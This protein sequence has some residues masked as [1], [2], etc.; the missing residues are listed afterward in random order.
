MRLGVVA[1]SL[2][3]LTVM[4]PFLGHS[5]STSEGSDLSG[6]SPS[7]NRAGESSSEDETICVLDQPCPSGEEQ[8]HERQASVS[9]RASFSSQRE[10]D[11]S[12]TPTVCLHFWYAPGCSHCA[13]VKEHLRGLRLAKYPYLE[14]RGHNARQE[15]DL[16]TGLLSDYGVAESK[17]GKVPVVYV[18]DDYCVGDAEC[19]E[20]VGA[21]IDSC[22]PGG[23]ACRVPTRRS[24]L[25][26]GLVGVASLAAVDAVNVCAL[27]VLIILITSV[28]T[29]FPEDRRRMLMIAFAFMGGI[30]AAYF[31]VGMLIV[32]GFKS[33][34]GIGSLSTSWIYRAVGVIAIALGIFNLKDFAWYG[35][36]G[37]KLEVPESWRPRMKKIIGSVVSPQGAL[38]VGLVVSVFLLP[39][40]LGPYF[41]AS[42]LL[43]GIPLGYALGWLLV[44]N[45]VFILPMLTITFVVYGGFGAI[46]NIEEWRQN[47]LRTLHLVAGVILCG[48]GAAIVAGWI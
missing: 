45:A 32:L 42:G 29:R 3:L 5:I 38:V 35:G 16:Y 26:V 31:A 27:A 46:T 12:N 20:R 17:R 48:I 22:L 14:I 25:K 30:F 11:S 44:Y 39:C 1:A 18:G 9:A 28:L 24:A 43:A 41:V 33:L 2:V 4:S 10:F 15:M 23:C 8:P 36:G 7:Q 21:M 40:A 34:A 13:R 37:F 6:D 47:H 19:L